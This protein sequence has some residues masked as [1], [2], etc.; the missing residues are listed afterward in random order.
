MAT[1]D[2]LRNTLDNFDL[3][4]GACQMLSSP[5]DDIWHD[6]LVDGVSLRNAA[7]FLFPILADLSLI[8]I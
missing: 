2:P 6:E 8:H 4:T 1:P 5:F 3:L 7:A